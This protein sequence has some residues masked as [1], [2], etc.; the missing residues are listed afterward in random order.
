MDKKTFEIS[1]PASKSI[2][3]RLLIL[4]SLFPEIQIENLSSARDTQLLKS[5]LENTDNTINVRDAGTAMRFALGYW[6]LKTKRPVLLTGTDRMLQRPVGPLVDALNQLGAKI[7]YTSRKGFP[8]IMV[9]P[10]VFIRNS[11]KVE[12]GISSQFISSLILIAPALPKGLFLEF[13]TEKSI[14]KPYWK[15]SLELVKELGVDYRIKNEGIQIY[16]VKKVVKTRFTVENDWSSA[17]YFY[18][19]TALYGKKIRLKNLNQNSLQ[20]DQILHQIYKQ[21]GVETVFI[22][23]TVI[24]HK[25]EIKYPDFIE[26]DCTNFPDLAQTLAVT[27]YGLKIPCRLTGLKTLRIKETDRIEALATELKKLHAV[28][29]AGKDYLEITPPS[30]FPDFKGEINTYK[31]HRMSM[32]FATLLPLFPRMNIRDKENVRKSFPGFWKEWRKLFP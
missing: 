1:L 13:E 28:V 14:S 17:S 7:E 22:N 26:M 4:Q 19:A 5:A 18:A 23:D 2:S 15:M 16:P 10:S 21:F 25:K 9:F 31:D 29:H 24:L 3:N 8:P 6:A 32:S 30:R 27:C 20:G 12:A 11:V